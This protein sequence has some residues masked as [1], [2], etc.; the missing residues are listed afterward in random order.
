[1]KHER[2]PFSPITYVVVSGFD[3]HV[4]FTNKF[5]L[6][7]YYHTKVKKI[8]KLLG[9]QKLDILTKQSII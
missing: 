6:R 4:I 9:K 3:L 5:C 2:D 8:D 7:N 1:M